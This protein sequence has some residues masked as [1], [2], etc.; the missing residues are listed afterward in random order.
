[1]LSKKEL[2][3]A[4][5]N[6]THLLYEKDE[7]ETIF[8]ILVED[9]GI[10]KMKWLMENEVEIDKNKFDTYLNQLKKNIPIQYVLGYEY[11]CGMKLKVSNAVLIPRPETEELVHLICKENKNLIGK[12]ILDIGTGSG[13]IALGLKK[14]L[15]KCSVL[16]LEK[17]AEAL[18]LA[19]ENAK[20]ENLDITFFQEDI[21][22]LSG[23]IKQLKIDIIVS[24]PP[25][26]SIK[27]KTE[28]E[29]RV[30]E[31]EPEMAL[32][33]NDNDPLLFYKKI[34]LLAIEILLPEGKIYFEIN[35]AFGNEL[36]T[37]SEENGF[38]C[39][40]KK[41]MYDNYRFAIL[42]KIRI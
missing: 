18:N 25:Y 41:D 23:A 22:N 2:K 8:F 6:A 5:D 13:C 42:K 36:K 30:Y 17:S 38:D 35:Q 19:Q 40:I 14:N 32:F 11:F 29:K 10:S 28:M 3:I 21:L 20:K 26:I 1:M 37:W 24:N 7:A 9:F 34:V 31:N 15:T 16:A 12:T 27:E 4:F 39:E 33:V